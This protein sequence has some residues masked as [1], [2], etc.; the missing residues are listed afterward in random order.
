MRAPISFPH[1]YS[2]AMCLV[3]SSTCC[4]SG[5]C[6]PASP[7]SSG[8]STRSVSTRSLR[9][10]ASFKPS[11]ARMQRGFSTTAP[12]SVKHDQHHHHR[13]QQQQRLHGTVTAFKHRRGYGFVLAEGVASSSRK[14]VYTSLEALNQGTSEPSDN[15]AA[16]ADS[17]DGSAAVQDDELHRT[18]FF[19]RGSLGGGFYVTEGERVSFAVSEVEPSLGKKRYLGAPAYNTAAGRFGATAAALAEEF[20]LDPTVSNT[21][22]EE[23]SAASRSNVH[24]VMMRLYDLRTQKE[25][26]ITPITLYGKVVEWN[27]VSGQGVIAELDVERE[28]HADAPCFP[29]S[30]EDMDLGQGTDMRVGRFVRFCLGP[31]STATKG[32]G[33]EVAGDDDDAEG[34]ADTTAAAGEGGEQLVAQRVIVDLTLERRRG[35]VGRPLVPS[36]AA[37]GTVTDQT[38]FNGV[39]REIRDHKFGFV[40]DDLSGE[41]IFFH[42]GNARANVRE[43][44]RVD[45]LLR[46]I[47]RGKHTGKKACYDVRRAPNE[48]V[49]RRRG[50]LPVEWESG[51]PAVKEEVEEFDLL[52]EEADVV[53]EHAHGQ[54]K[55]AASANGGKRAVSVSKAARKKKPSAATHQNE[56]L[57]FN[58]L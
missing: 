21:P 48:G 4:S 33:S 13:Q 18:Y 24:A 30:I 12:C 14:P 6:S 54:A 27:D 31:S 22:V 49:V 23:E 8:T 53:G 38:R 7:L 34:A 42:A 51:E 29:V 15:T 11:L 55:A 43:G 39:V 25:S 52:E 41:S 26:P 20:S 57:D 19:T 10:A 28:Y 16:S 37:P 17:E 36:T 50:D 40:I 3:A 35:A 5:C 32:S 58:L 9:F 46:E 56:E 47:L 1:L 2:P 45:Y 44:D